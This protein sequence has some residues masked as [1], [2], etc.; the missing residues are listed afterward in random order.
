MDKNFYTVQDIMRIL[1]IQKTKAYS[2]IN[3]LNQ[4]LINMGY[5]ICKGRV[6]RTYFERCYCY[7]E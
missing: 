6:N 1:S 3:E 7:Q 5:R 2:I 4:E